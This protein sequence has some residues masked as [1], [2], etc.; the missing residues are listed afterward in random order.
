MEQPFG[1]HSLDERDWFDRRAHMHLTLEENLS[2]DAIARGCRAVGERAE[3][4][5]VR[6]G[7][8]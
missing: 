5:V 3:G 1:R 7:A 4:S 2:H 8:H 6:C